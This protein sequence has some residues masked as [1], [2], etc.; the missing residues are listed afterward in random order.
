MK[1]KYSVKAYKIRL[2]ALTDFC[3]SA[4]Q[5]AVLES[6]DYIIHDKYAYIIDSQAVFNML[7]DGIISERD[8]EDVKEFLKNNP[9]YLEKYFKTRR[10]ELARNYKNMLSINR[11][12]RYL[13]VKENEVTENYAVP[14]STIKG[15]L[16]T[17]FLSFF[18]EDVEYVYARGQKARL[19]LKSL[20]VNNAQARIDNTQSLFK[21][22]ESREDFQ[23]G[24]KVFYATQGSWK[25]KGYLDEIRA[26]EDGFD[27]IEHDL[28]RTIK[29]LDA[30]CKEGSFIV[31]KVKRLSRA[32]NR[33]ALPRYFELAQKGSIFVGK[34]QVSVPHDGEPLSSLSFLYED[35]NYIEDLNVMDIC[36]EGL[37]IY[38]KK[39]VKAEEKF[40][41]QKIGN[42]NSQSQN[43]YNDLWSECERGN[44][45]IKIG[46]SGIHAKSF[47]S[48]DS[49]NLEKNDF[50]PYT[51]NIDDENKLPIGWVK[52]EI[53][54]E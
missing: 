14:A 35:S 26:A 3:V 6:S 48:F 1:E 51:I 17:G 16:K 22:F 24:L 39:L 12:W 4:N 53:E 23:K 52:L 54:E 9:E 31:K 15:I 46:K 50:F 32:N 34:V 47:M 5:D 18:L 29:C 40:F 45:I 36:I 27:S 44:I 28:F 20:K 11:F 2:R 30:V 42:L 49:N 38:S 43:F 25:Q 7:K 41:A 10:L 13:D 33:S 8:L 19:N 21:T 37:K